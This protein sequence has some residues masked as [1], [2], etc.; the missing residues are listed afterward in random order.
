[1]GAAGSMNP[2]PAAGGAGGAPPSALGRAVV[3]VGGYGDNYPFQ[4]YDLD[5]ETGTLSERGGPVDAGG[6]PTYIAVFGD[7][8]YVANERDDDQ[9][10]VT[11]LAIDPDGN[12]TPLNHQTGSDGGFAYVAVDPTGS[13]AFGASYNGG[14]VSVFPIEQDGSLGP[15]THNVDFG[16]GAQSHCVGFSGT[17]V[18]IPNKGNDEV[19]QMTLA[20]DG[21]LAPLAPPQVDTAGGAGPRHI[22]IRGTFAWLINELNSTMSSYTIQADGALALVN[23][24]STLPDGAGNQNS[25]AHVEV[26]P[27]GTR[28]YGSNRGDNSIVVFSADA[29]TGEL[30]LLEHVASGGSTPRDFDLDQSGQFLIVANQD[31]G[32]LVVFDTGGGESLQPLGSPVSAP[33]SPAA[34][35]IVYLD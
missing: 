17:N 27:D 30:A 13:Y 3:Y 19:A 11:A 16:N 5:T 28:V 6:N 4:A 15:E 23:T 21:T 32:N 26:S 22:A 29:A 35:Q 12:L 2:E 1:M 24:L 18:Y 33:P 20:G 34:V 7:H 8:L 14:S 25:G 31:T 9:G 10:G